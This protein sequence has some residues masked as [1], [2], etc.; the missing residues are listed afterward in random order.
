MK[1]FNLGITA[2]TAVFATALLAQSNDTVGNAPETTLKVNSRAVLVDVIVTDKNGNPVKGL[3]QDDFRVLEQGKKQ[4]ISYFEEHTADLLA[5]RGQNRAFPAMPPNVFSNFS[6]L[7]TPPA[8][9]VLLLDALN[10]PMA[11]QMYLKKA[12]QHYLKTLKPGTRLAIFTMSMRLSFIQGFSDDPAVLATALGYRKNDRSE[13]AVLLQSPEESDAQGTVI[14]MMVEME[15][16]GSNQIV[17]TV[18]PETIAAFQ[19]FMQ[20][21]RYAQDSDREYRTLQNLNQLAAFLGAF[22]GRKNVIWMSGAFPLELFGQTSMRFEGSIDKTVNLLSAARIAIYPVDVRGTNVPAFYTAENKLDPTITSAPQLLGPPP[23]VTAD[24]PNVGQ[25]GLA[26]GLQ[27]ERQ[28]KNASDSTMDML[29]EQTGGK[30]FY[31]Q[32]DLSGIIAKVTDH[33][34]NFYTISY[35]PNDTKMDGSYRKIEVK[36]GDGEHYTLSYRQGYFARDE[37]LPGAAQS[38]QNQAAQQASQDP[39]KIDPLAPFMVFGMPTSEQI[40]YKALIQHIPPKSEQSAVAKPSLKGPMDRYSVDFALDLN[41]LNLK[42]DP[43]GSHKGALNL[44]MIVYNKYGQTNS[45]EDHLVTLSIKP[46]VYA[47]FQKTGVQMH[48]EIMVPK[49]QFWLRTGVYDEVSRKVGTMEVPL[50]SVKDSVASK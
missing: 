39:T 29:A 15:Q 43:D 9:N 14:E 3:K 41:D 32:N 12:A 5:R 21:T 26:G 49:G 8:V 45:R 40:L 47:I 2:L 25:G 28:K 23:G 7:P 46:D 37:D 4:S 6:P 10:T 19:Q 35:A 11:D 24:A 48:G 44:S 31:N 34:S 22:P 30:A 17:F 42:L 50:S 20:E 36:V 18:S 33:S 38:S 27:D 13:P 16:A 1:L